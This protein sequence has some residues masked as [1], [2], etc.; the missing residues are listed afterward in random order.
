M[1][2]VCGMNGVYWMYWVKNVLH[3]GELDYVELCYDEFTSVE[4]SHV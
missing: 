3:L 2:L 4:L 1:L